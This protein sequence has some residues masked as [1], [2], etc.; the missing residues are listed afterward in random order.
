MGRSVS[1]CSKENKNCG[2]YTATGFQNTSVQI[3][4]D[5]T[6]PLLYEPMTTSQH[7]KNKTTRKRTQKLDN[8]TERALAWPLSP[9]HTTSVLAG[10]SGPKHP[11]VQRCRRHPKAQWPTLTAREGGMISGLPGIASVQLLPQHVCNI[12]ASLE[13]GYCRAVA[14]AGWRS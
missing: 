14:V 7:P 6:L 2:S 1:C 4:L 8:L 10:A 5:W 3:C 13:F 12:H 11:S 9:M